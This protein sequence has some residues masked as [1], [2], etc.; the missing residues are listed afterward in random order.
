MAERGGNGEQVRIEALMAVA[1]LS[2]A[3]ADFL[4]GLRRDLDGT[5]RR[6][7]FALNPQEMRDARRYFSFKADDSNDEITTAMGEDLE[8]AANPPSGERARYWRTS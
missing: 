7:G 4:N 3:D 2:I 8:L 6:H 1:R 5:L